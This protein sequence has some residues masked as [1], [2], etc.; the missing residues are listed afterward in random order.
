GNP[1]GSDKEIG[2]YTLFEVEYINYAWGYTHE[3]FFIDSLGDVYTYQ[4]YR[5]GN[6]IP[7]DTWQPANFDTLA[8]QE[9][10]EKYSHNPALFTTINKSVLTEKFS[11]VEAA[12]KG[13]MSERK[14]VCADI[15]SW[16][17][18]AYKFDKVRNHYYK[19]NLYQSGDLNWRNLSPEAKVL[20]EWLKS[21]NQKYS[22]PG[23]D[24]EVK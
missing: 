9:L 8:P 17:Y 5:E 14:M 18:V 23:C 4:Y 10:A 7:R 20:T 11:L 24:F 12:A 22:Q 6:H 19:V 2:Q 15:G 16:Y 3:G 21:I 13:K 1:P